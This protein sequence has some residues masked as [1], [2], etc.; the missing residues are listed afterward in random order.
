LVPIHWYKHDWTNVSP[1]FY[2]RKVFKRTAFGSSIVMGFAIASY[3]NPGDGWRSDKLKNRPDMKPYPAMVKQDEDDEA[4]NSMKKALY[5]KHSGD[6]RKQ[7][8]WYR[9]MFPLDAD[10]TIKE[11]PYR[12]N[13][14]RE[15]WDTKESVMSTWGNEALD[16]VA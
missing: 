2:S 9:F 16:H 6:D 14:H 4:V 13:N 5:K 1:G 3:L 7:S 10:Y 8:S 15:L 11:N 12:V